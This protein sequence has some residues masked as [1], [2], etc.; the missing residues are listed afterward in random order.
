MMRVRP[1]LLAL[2]V[3]SGWCRKNPAGSTPA[4]R[5]QPPPAPAAAQHAWDHRPGAGAETFTAG[6]EQATRLLGLTLVTFGETLYASL[7]PQAACRLLLAAGRLTRLHTLTLTRVC[8]APAAAAAC[9]SALPALRSFRLYGWEMKSHDMRVM[10]PGLACLSG[11]THLRLSGNCLHV[12]G[13]SELM[14]ALGDYIGQLRSLDLPNNGL[15][16]GGAALVAASLHAATAIT[17]LD[18]STNGLTDAGA[19]AISAGIRGRPIPEVASVSADGPA[20]AF[21]RASSA[22]DAPA[23][24]A[25]PEAGAG[26]TQPPVARGQAVAGHRGEAGGRGDS[27]IGAAALR[28]LKLAGNRFTGAGAEAVAEA[29]KAHDT[30]EEVSIGGVRGTFDAVG[31]R[32]ALCAVNANLMFHVS[33]VDDRAPEAASSGNRR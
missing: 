22:S 28:S 30:I 9:L 24:D 17:R 6:L 11:L 25:V 21:S 31:L 18:L 2:P 20:D 10:A 16:D 3:C 19:Y 7:P 12:V 32:A 33:E 27:V 5:L 13:A 15:M 29:V 1:P 8:G 14:H 26:A 4:Q 23:T